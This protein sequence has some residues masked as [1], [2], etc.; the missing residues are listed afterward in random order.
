MKPLLCLSIASCVCSNEHRR[1]R[2]REILHMLSQLSRILAFPREKC[3]VWHI[4]PKEKHVF[5]LIHLCDNMPRYETSGSVIILHNVGVH[6]SGFNGSF[7]AIHEHHWPTV[8]CFFHPTVLM[9]VS[10]ILKAAPLSFPAMQLNGER[11]IEH[12]LCIFEHKA[13]MKRHFKS[14]FAGFVWGDG[15]S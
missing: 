9:F 4:Q 14:D 15:S 10:V 8:L 6:R 12:E 5:L 7:K 2:R 13:P 11:L 1:N 3:C